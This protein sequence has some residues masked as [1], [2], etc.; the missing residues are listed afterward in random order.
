MTI[1]PIM[2]FVIIQRLKYGYVNISNETLVIIN[3]N[4]TIRNC[5]ITLTDFSVSHTMDQIR[6]SSHR[7]DVY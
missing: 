2:A 3:L 7:T 1:Y 6:C 5:I 4:N